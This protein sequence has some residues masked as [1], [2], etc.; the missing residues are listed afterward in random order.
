MVTKFEFVRKN[1]RILCSV[2]GGVCLKPATAD[3]MLVY[4]DETDAP[5]FITLQ[6]LSAMTKE[7]ERQMGAELIP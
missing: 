4:A 5:L 3:G 7:V 2:V 1:E 6:M